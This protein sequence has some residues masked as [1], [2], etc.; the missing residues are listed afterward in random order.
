MVLMEKEICTNWQLS[1]LVEGENRGYFYGDWKVW[2]MV[3]VRSPEFIEAAIPGPPRSVRSGYCETAT[4]KTWKHRK[5]FCAWVT[6]AKAKRFTK[7]V[8]PADESIWWWTLSKP[9]R[10]DEFS[11]PEELWLLEFESKISPP[12]HALTVFSL[13]LILNLYVAAA[14]RRSRYALWRDAPVTPAT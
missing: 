14:S 7:S 8:K 12:V 13:A 2:Y 4:P 10:A 6:K 5:N 1:Q 9:A 11:E 3:A